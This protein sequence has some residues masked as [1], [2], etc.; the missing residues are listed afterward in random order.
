MC[1]NPCLL[2]ISVEKTPLLLWTLLVYHIFNSSGAKDDYPEVPG[3]AIAP[4]LAEVNFYRNN[5]HIIKARLDAQKTAA[6]QRASS[7]SVRL[8]VKQ[9]K[10]LTDNILK[11]IGMLQTKKTDLQSNTSALGTAVML[12]YVDLSCLL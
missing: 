12:H 6:K 10:M 7:I 4:L 3:S 11:Q 2:V 8:E 9:Q 5:S 1:G